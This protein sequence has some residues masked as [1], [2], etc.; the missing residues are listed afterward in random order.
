[1]PARVSGTTDLL[2]TERLRPK[3]LS[4]LIGNA[5][6]IAELTAWAAGWAPGRGPPR[7][8]A[9]LLEGRA[10]VGKTSAAGALAHDMGWSV[11]EMNASEARNR[12]AIEQVA[13]RAALTNSFS[14]DGQYRS[15]KSGGRTLIL[16]DE[17]DCLTGRATEDRAPAKAPPTL[18]EF[19]RARYGTVGSLAEA[20]GLGRPKAPP[21]FAG[22]EEVPT[23]GGRGAWTRLK[24]AQV[25][26]AEWREAGS[27]EDLSDRGG[28]GAI[29][30]LVKSTLQPVILT[31]N[32]AQTL[33]RYS[34]L[35]RQGVAR[36][37]FLPVAD[38]EMRAFLR[39]TI[40][41]ERLEIQT[42]AVEAI[43]RRSHG[44]L[45]AALNDLDAIAPLPAGPAQVAVLGARDVG[46]EFETF[47]SEAL[48]HA[49]F[50]RMVEVRDRLDASPD[51]LF[52]WIEEAVPHA[53]LDAAHRLAAFE[54][55]G[56]AELCLMRARRFRHWGLWSYAT[57]LMTG[58]VATA[59]DRPAGS[60]AVYAGFPMFL[61][62]MGRS[63]IAR[64]QRKAVL[65]RV[66]P[67]FHLSAR[68]GSVTVLPWLYRLF[69]PPRPGF[70]RPAARALRAEIIHRTRLEAD[71]VAYLMDLEPDSAAVQTELLRSEPRSGG[72]GVAPPTGGASGRSGPLGPEAPPETEPSEATALRRPARAT[73]Q[74]RLS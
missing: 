66:D 12:R 58:G 68:K 29:A 64:A 40:L 53:A 22:W 19:L 28:L 13:G 32:D 47:V 9:A 46:S 7:Q 61:A 59:L 55:L 14:S 35:F 2:L 37:R 48:D 33:T 67:F 49:R 44:D 1:M 18:R 38:A 27:P 11:V 24:A 10:G 21:A 23:T 56:R 42:A 31:V 50:V 6:A 45:R 70:D 63:R 74:Q 51:D 36:V 65:E 52:P 41:A 69:D 54:T 26:L 15:A 17:A 34:P 30:Q 73:R 16:L 4:E 62:G 72:P 71:Q 3:R 57:E 39:K 25:D 5:G 8:R 20:W 60:G 43:V